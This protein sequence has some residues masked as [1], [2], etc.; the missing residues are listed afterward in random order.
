[1]LELRNILNKKLN[2]KGFTLAELLVVVAILAILVAVSIPI[3]TGKL[4]KAKEATDDANVR[5]AKAAAVTEYLSSEDAGAA[6]L[7]NEYYNADTGV[8]VD[9]AEKAKVKGE[10]YNQAKQDGNIDAKEGVIHV[11]IEPA[12]TDTGNPTVTATW[13]PADTAAGGTN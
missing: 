11:E 7:E 5:A 6:T 10:G 4:N 2:K 8:M 9:T 13:V 1:M 3:F 12:E